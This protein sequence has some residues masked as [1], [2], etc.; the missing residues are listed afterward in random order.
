[1]NHCCI[2]LQTAAPKQKMPAAV[3]LT[4]AFLDQAFG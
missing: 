2:A 4:Q 3:E 1:M